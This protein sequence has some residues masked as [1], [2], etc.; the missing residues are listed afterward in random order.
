MKQTVYLSTFRDAFQS[1]RPDDFSREGLELLFEYLEDLERDTGEEYELDVIALCCDFCEDDAEN[2]VRE[3]G[4]A[5]PDELEGEEL[6]E[7]VVDQLGEDTS[8]VG[9]T[10][11]GTIVYQVF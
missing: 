1:I 5:N 8:V 9:A 2:I 4:M 3:Y 11:A 6:A 10:S 7:Y